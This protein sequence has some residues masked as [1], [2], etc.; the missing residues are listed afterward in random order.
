MVDRRSIPNKRNNDRAYTSGAPEDDDVGLAPSE[1][2]RDEDV[3]TFIDQILM[4]SDSNKGVRQIKLI[5]VTA[6]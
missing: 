3:D 4:L 5:F 2:W 6:C 1:D